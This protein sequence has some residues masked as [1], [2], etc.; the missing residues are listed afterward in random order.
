[1][2]VFISYSH[3]D[4][5]FVDKL[6]LQLVKARAQV[7]LDRWELAVGDSLVTRI[8]DAVSGASA[9]VVVLSKAS[10][11]SEWCRKELSAGLVRELE[12]R[13]V[14]VMPI[15][16]E[17]CDIPLFLRDKKH[18]DFRA[19][20][21]DGLRDLLTGIAR[22]T[23]D[24]RSRIESPEWHLDWAIDWGRIAERAVYVITFVEQAIDRPYSTLTILRV[25]GN[26]NATRRFDLYEREELGWV[27]RHIVLE[28]LADSAKQID[29]R[30]VL[31]DPQPQHRKFGVK[32]ERLGIEWQAD[33][34]CRLLGQDTGFDV[35]LNI[36]G[37]L[38]SAVTH[39][40]ASSRR[41]TTDE[42][43][44]LMQVLGTLR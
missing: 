36:A 30:M 34:E 40:R 1:V 33:I 26:E 3:K 29:L 35:L 11:A 25:T 21:D 10:V 7:W 14:V 15:L 37:Q 32:D 12:E 24:T 41:P 17:D 16:F 18:A 42:Q 20:F 2:P 39:V 43:R 13:R 27:Y 23:T 8:Q 9:L 6:A 44:R 4:K 19:N 38:E 5:T 28:T 22:V 31:H